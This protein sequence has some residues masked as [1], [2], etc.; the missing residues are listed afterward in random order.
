MSP[1]EEIAMNDSLIE[2]Y[3]KLQPAKFSS[4][5]SLSIKQ[6]VP[7]NAWYGIEILMRLA[8]EDGKKRLELHFQGA[9]DFSFRLDGCVGGHLVM[10]RSIKSDQWED[11]DYRVDD[12]EWGAFSFYCKSFTAKFCE[13]EEQG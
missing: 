8:S 7:P 9:R 2:E 3:L 4:L 11:L 1:E 13:L 6:P 12:D 10:I 5:E